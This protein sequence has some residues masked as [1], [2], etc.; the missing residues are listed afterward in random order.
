MR[1]YHKKW[2]VANT[3]PQSIYILLILYLIFMGLQTLRKAPRKK[4]YQLEEDQ[5]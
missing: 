5:I 1:S 4:K 2:L 3:L